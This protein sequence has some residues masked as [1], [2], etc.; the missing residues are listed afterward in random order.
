[1]RRR[2]RSCNSG[3]ALG[4]LAFMALN[5]S[6]AFARFD[7]SEPASSGPPTEQRQMPADQ[8]PAPIVRFPVAWRRVPDFKAILEDKRQS[9]QTLLVSELRFCR[10]A[11][12]LTKEQGER[13]ALEAGVMVEEAACEAARLG[14]IPAK[15]HGIWLNTDPK[16]PNPVKLIRS[17]LERLVGEC[18]TPLQQ[19]RYVAEAKKRDAHRRETAIHALVARLDRTLMLSTS[20]REQLLKMFESNWDEEW[21]VLSGV[22]GDDEAPLPAIPERL[23]APLLTVSQRMAWKRFD[24]VAL[25]STEAY[26]AVVAEIMEG[27]PT[28]FAPSLEAAARRAEKLHGWTEKKANPKLR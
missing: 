25:D 15:R 7:D 18:A 21:G 23:I 13:I 4:A 17:I 12:G 1:M 11:S 26:L 6:T 24:I 19:R 27:L 9:Y 5:G 28:E 22:M 3:W 16:P 20:Q 8:P 10:S 2:F 14:L